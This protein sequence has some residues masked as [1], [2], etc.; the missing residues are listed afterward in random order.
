MGKGIIKDIYDEVKSTIE[1]K[2][3][4]IYPIKWRKRFKQECPLSLLLLNLWLEPLF[5]IIEKDESIHG[6]YM[7]IP[8]RIIRFTTQA[9]AD[10]VIFISENPDRII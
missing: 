7:E 5:E 8:E 10:N 6:A 1:Y 2:G 3:K 9:D 4:Q